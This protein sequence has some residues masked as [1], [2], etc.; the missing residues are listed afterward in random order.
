MNSQTGLDYIIEN[1]EFNQKLANGKYS[2]P[3][4]DSYRGNFPMSRGLT[5]KRI[6][7]PYSKVIAL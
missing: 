6:T 2:F 5:Q 7:M 4:V 3:V 1:E